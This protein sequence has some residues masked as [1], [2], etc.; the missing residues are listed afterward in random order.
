MYYLEDKMI[1]K[2]NFNYIAI[3][4]NELYR[5]KKNIENITHRS[6]LLIK[7]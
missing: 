3:R 7:V 4:F 1:N 6:F 2:Q 5:N